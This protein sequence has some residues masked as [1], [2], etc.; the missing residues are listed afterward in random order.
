MGKENKRP[1]EV[2]VLRPFFTIGSG[3]REVKGIVDASRHQRLKE[4]EP[5]S[6]RANF[7]RLN[8]IMI[9]TLSYLNN[10]SKLIRVENKSTNTGA[11]NQERATPTLGLCHGVF[12]DQFIFRYILRHFFPR[13]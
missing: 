6:W 9:L 7:F 3:G 2:I 10:T 1:P 11:H 4:T 8:M 5:K 13:K 12:T